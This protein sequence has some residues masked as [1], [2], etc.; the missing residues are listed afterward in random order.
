LFKGGGTVFGPR[1]RSYGFKL[2]KKQ[3][4]LARMSAL[5]YKAKDQNILI[6]EDLKMDSPKTKDFVN[7]LTSL[8]VNDTKTL[9]VVGDSDKNVYLSSRNVQN[10]KVIEAS[11]V[12]T[13]DVLS[14]GKLIIAESAV[15][16]IDKLFN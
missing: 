15:D 5:A 10:T 14:A 11:Q 8:K 16:K 9:L 4:R 1:P 2:N 13:Y 6:L 12:N 7:V 3:R